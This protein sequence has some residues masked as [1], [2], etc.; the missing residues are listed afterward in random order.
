MSNL[1]KSG[2][3]AFSQDQALVIDANDNKIIKGI[4]EAIQEAAAAEE[5]SMEDTLAEA[6]IEDAQ[7][8]ESG[9]EDSFGILEVSDGTS[10]QQREDAEQIIAQA[11]NEAQEIVD[12]AHDEVEQ[13]RATAYDEAE[14]IK[15]TAR[16]D[17]YQAGYQEGLHA[18]EEEYQ[19][20]KQML[21]EQMNQYAQQQQQEQ[22]TFV[23]DMEQNMVEWLCR[24]I[25]SITGV[26]IED[27]K[28]VLLYMVNEA[29]KNLDD[30]KQFVVKVSEEDYVTLE[31]QKEQIYG[32]SNP[33][34]DIE[35]FADAKLSS[36]QCLIET[37]NGVVDVSLDVQLANLNKALRLMIKE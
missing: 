25:P 37:E 33:N 19:Q 30:C 8:G 27:Q 10:G 7:L 21:Q 5:P 29:I 3:V 18:V 2:F 12:K 32:Y 35:L 24:M 15:S 22:E 26:T 23:T 28:S 9:D 6:M 16:S 34:V 14:Q 1:I 13:M 36:K 20:K 31:S 17:G 4:D 11:K